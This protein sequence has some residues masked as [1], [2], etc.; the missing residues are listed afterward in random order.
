[1]YS[2][3]AL[4]D[5][6]LTVSEINTLIKK[7]FEERFFNL[8]VTG[9]ISSFR[10]SGN[11]HWYFT[12]KDSQSQ[13]SAVMFRS[14]QYKLEFRPKD[15]DLVTV[16]G[17]IDV[18][19]PRGTYQ[20]ICQSMVKAGEGAILAEIEKRKARYES[21]GYF[22]LKDKKP[23]PRTP[24]RIGVVTASTGA[25]IQDILKATGERA[26]S[27]D[28]TLYE[29]LVQGKNASQLIA[30]AIDMANED[31]TCDVL[32]VGRG[33]GSIEDLLPFSE[34]PVIEAIHRSRIPVISAVGHEIDWSISDYVADQ[35][36]I[37]PT[38]GAVIATAGIFEI[39]KQLHQLK[40]ELSAVMERRLLI[41][42]QSIPSVTELALL[43][44][45]RSQVTLPSPEDLRLTLLR[46]IDSYTMRLGF[47]SD[48]AEEA[49]LAT[50]KDRESRI[51]SLR[52]E[53]LSSLPRLY[54]ARVQSLRFA[55]AAVK[56]RSAESTLKLEHRIELLEKEAGSAIRDK[57]QRNETR[58]RAVSGSLEAL[59]PEEVLSR[60]Y[61][62]VFDGQHKV[63]RDS[64]K[65]KAGDRLE[66]KLGKGIVKAL[67]EG[68]GK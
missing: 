50:L 8:C 26:P 52:S 59:N 68:E 39:R 3:F 28:I 53:A 46:R 43:M 23:I 24:S 37:T 35:R 18:Y 21:M 63:V 60:G 30:N 6:P 49:V 22:D 51:R 62:I 17:N 44:K 20:I 55:T 36:A 25:A 54:S 4:I 32:I 13:L 56:A 29:T 38:E 48:G 64:S 61:A 33:G 9:E 2:D 45:S 5:T 16:T 31:A 58:L 66:I 14:M 12:L 67:A 1:M 19:A 40:D 7:T 57:L 15:G 42:R 41:A 47:A 11:G 34:E 27:V 65:V 10:P